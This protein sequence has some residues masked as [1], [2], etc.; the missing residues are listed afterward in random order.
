[1]TVLGGAD[2]DRTSE[3]EIDGRRPDQRRRRRR[4]RIAVLAVAVGVVVILGAGLTVRAL[5]HVRPGAQVQTGQD[6]DP[7]WDSGPV[8]TPP[9][10]SRLVPYRMSDV[11]S[12]VRITEHAPKLGD[13]TWLAVGKE[14]RVS[15]GQATM[16]A[17]AIGRVDRSGYLI[18]TADDS[19]VQPRTDGREVARV[20]VSGHPAVITTTPAE[21]TTGTWVSWLLDDG[22]RI[23]AWTQ[24]ADTNDALVAFAETLREEPTPL[25]RV[26]SLG[27][28]LPGL[29]QQVSSSTPDPGYVGSTGIQ[30]CPAGPAVTLAT[31]SIQ[32]SCLDVTTLLGGQSE[33]LA[34][35]GRA[36]L[37]LIRV[38]GRSMFYGPRRAY[39]QPPPTAITVVDSPVPLSCT[40][41]AALLAAARHDPALG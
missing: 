15:W 3:P 16:P 29:T 35:L 23:H 11:V 18:T 5:T 41:M 8:P 9:A 14:I 36:D 33:K 24:D 2:A 25:T 31:T 13:L 28:T 38:N 10:G 4:R 12:P 7:G 40:D 39:Q 17:N 1:M 22:R 27:L 21:S 30:L 32:A 6:N 34:A 20:A 19:A 26:F 37:T